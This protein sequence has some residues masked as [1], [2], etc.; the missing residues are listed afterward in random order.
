[1][2]LCAATGVVTF[3]LSAI[4]FALC[5]S[6]LAGWIMC[7]RHTDNRARR[8][9]AEQAERRKPPLKFHKVKPGDD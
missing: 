1:M 2:F 5:L 4:I 6:W 7:A 9:A 8:I 3:W